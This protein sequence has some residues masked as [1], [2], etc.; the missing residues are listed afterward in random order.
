MVCGVACGVC[1]VCGLC[2]VWCGVWCLW[3]VVCGV[4]CGF[5]IQD[6]KNLFCYKYKYMI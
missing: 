2:D 1:G 6:S 3:C 5:K 4:V